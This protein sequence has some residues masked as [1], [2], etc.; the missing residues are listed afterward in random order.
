MKYARPLGTVVEVGTTNICLVDTAPL[1]FSVLKLI[2]ANG[3]AM[4]KYNGRALHTYEVVFDLV[5][6]RK[7]DL[8]GLV[9]HRF[10]TEQYREAMLALTQRGRSGV[11]K[12]VFTPSTAA[13]PA[14]RRL[15]LI[16]GRTRR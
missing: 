8:S 14:K 12:A 1:W 16:P 15:R 5:Q 3:R 11:I 4:D 13:E 10:T 2:G 7:I 6:N 9:T